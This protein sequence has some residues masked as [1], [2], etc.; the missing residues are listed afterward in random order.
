M[1]AVPAG[2]TLTGSVHNN[3]N[4]GPSLSNTL[5]VPKKQS[6]LSSLVSISS[7]GRNVSKSKSPKTDPTLSFVRT[8]GDNGQ[9]QN[10]KLADEGVRSPASSKSVNS[11]KMI[12][13]VDDNETSQTTTSLKAA[14]KKSY[15][16][17][18]HDAI[19]ALKDRTGSSQ[20][21]IQKYLLGNH[22][23]LEDGKT[24]RTRVGMAL[25]SGV[26]QTRFIKL[27]SSFKVNTEWVK[28]TKANQRAKDKA[29]KDRDRKKR[30]AE[31]KEIQD[32]MPVKKEETLD[33][34]KDS[35]PQDEY[36]KI[37]QKHD[38]D[39]DKQRKKD[40]AE[41]LRKER[42]ER[43][44][45]RR[46]PMEDTKLHLEDKELAVKPP[47]DVKKRPGL[48]YVFQLVRDNKNTAETPSR[49][50]YLDHGS[51]GLIPDLLQIYHFFRG[52]VH[53]SPTDD[54]IVPEFSLPH[55]LFAVDEIL[56]GNAKKSRMVPPLICHLFVTCLGLLT[57]TPIAKEA[58]VYERRLQKD[59]ENLALA[60]GPPSWAEICCQY[61]EAMERYYTTSASVDPNVLSPGVTDM[62][63]LM[64]VKSNPDIT[65]IE[66]TLPNG[67]TG[68]IG[69]PNAALA[70]GHVKLMRH[71]PWN[72]S[73]DELI[74]LLRALTED[75][76]ATRP[77]L[78]DD[79]AQRDEQMYELIK[80]KRIADL[81]F[82][83]MRLAFEGP[84][85]KGKAKPKEEEKKD[86]YAKEEPTDEQDTEEQG[87]LDCDKDIKKE[88]SREWKPTA[89][90]KQFDSAVKA[91]EKAHDA[92]EKGVR[93][94]M[95]RT[96]PVGYDRHYNRVYYFHH[97]PQILYVEM[98][99]TP[100]GLA[101]HLPADLQINRTS[102]HAIENRSVFDQFVASL[103][104]RGNRENDL[105]ETM[106][107]PAGANKSLKRHLVDDIKE[108]SVI[109]N[110]KK[111]REELER[112]R[113]NAI[114]ACKLEEEGGGR[115]SGRFQS[116]NEADLMQINVDIDEIEKKIKIDETPKVPDYYELTGMRVLEKF[117]GASKRQTRRSRE[118]KGAS[119]INFP[120]MPCS[121]LWPTGN[122]DGSGIVGWIVSEL[123]NIEGLCET[124]CP[125]Q[126]TGP[127]RKGWIADVEGT[128]YSWYTSSPPAIG[129]EGDDG[130]RD[131]SL[132]GTASSRAFLSVA[133]GRRQSVES[134][135]SDGKRRK[136]ESPI[137][138]LGNF[139]QVSPASVLST[140]KNPLLELEER[141]YEL[142][143]LATAERDAGEADD[144]MS[145]ASDDEEENHAKQMNLWKKKIFI[146]R[147]MPAKKHTQV[148]ELLVEAIS[149]A[150]KA[151]L[152]AVVG[153]LRSA[154]LLHQPSASG[155]CKAA[156]LAI[157]QEYGGYEVEDESD[158][159]IDEEEGKEAEDEA[160]HSL[161]DTEAMMLTGSLNGDEMANR[162]DWIEGVKDCK[163][164]SRFAALVLAFSRNAT[165]RLE[166]IR[167]ESTAL[168]HVLDGYEK[169]QD[170]ANRIRG[171]GKA[172]APPKKAPLHATEVWANVHITD[173]FCMVKLDGSPWWPARKCVAKDKAIQNRITSL[174]L[175][176]LSV[177]GEEQEGGFRIVKSE[178]VRKF[179]EEPIDEDL[180]EYPKWTRNQLEEFL[181][182]SRRIIRGRTKANCDV[183]F[184][185][186][187]KTAK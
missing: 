34:L 20:M 95:A 179:S 116:Q 16:Q 58:N 171:N 155:D 36:I 42:A 25:K 87:E 138:M 132:S 67:Y 161:L 77:E 158:D 162:L 11:A 15:V 85:H 168:F 53:F 169:E 19:I 29:R 99:R 71:D 37:K 41:L 164:L 117:D 54:P 56:N 176:L 72:L 100:T 38:D 173:E 130:P 18:A 2:G 183:G 8:S 113:Q 83:K 124:L 24:F 122:I 78:A 105:Y 154:L 17:L 175:E 182:T 94:L 181:A 98:I 10:C 70:K 127:G 12:T 84:K 28:R 121:K 5:S 140:L 148:R 27:K 185:E 90:K 153:K 14:G 88:A 21:A 114:L 104:I 74:A 163:T 147:N 44:R 108:Q 143:G 152:P 82:R 51:R 109:A 160:V 144:N 145:T 123:L 48:P 133:P 119:E 49:C 66:G 102:W 30:E 47:D 31:R 60:L 4:A 180:S 62:L 55:L 52:D 63:F 111:D 156:A 97:D 64:K 166:K 150:R 57:S 151:H 126:R 172:K 177:L 118:K 68:Y 186:E 69:S 112:K 103:D 7:T 106:V 6:V 40:V 170:R 13:T 80:A 134:S 1:P 174:D 187:K 9:G 146:I 157:L 101:N 92:Y 125:W 26:T 73:A 35:L 110:R 137:S 59:L 107:G 23:D 159:E 89:T 165:S 81:H 96:D 46:F 136:L 45:K 131:P 129:P 79:L 128:V 22:P 61:M 135:T 43:L 142:T 91:Q 167:D 33:D 141:I 32:A 75:V 65:E 139:S 86:E 115:R 3:L 184:V 149:A 93:N 39:V 50:Q 76:L 178:L 120:I